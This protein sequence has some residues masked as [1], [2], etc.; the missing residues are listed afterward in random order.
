MTEYMCD[1]CSTRPATVRVAIVQD[2]RRRQLDVCD[3]HYRQLSRHQRQLSPL[4]SLFRGGTF[5]DFLNVTGSPLGTSRSS[6]ADHVSAQHNGVDLDRHF[7]DQSKEYL[8]RAA[9]RAAQRGKREIDT[10]DLL[11]ALTESDL[12]ETI[13]SAFRLSGEALRA[14]IESRAKSVHPQHASNDERF[15]VSPRLKSAL[16]R[17]FLTSRQMGRPMSVRSTCSLV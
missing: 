10:E 8:Q 17:A 11:Y 1:L 15:A 6:D 3:Y 9:A 16:D 5:G 13:L 7:S 4:E 2:G 12:V 14:T